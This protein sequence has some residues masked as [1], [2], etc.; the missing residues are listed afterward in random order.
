MER[1]SRK[2]IKRLREEGFEEVSTR[3]SHHKFRKGQTVLIVPHP[4]KDLPI[5]TAREIARQAGWIK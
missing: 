5:G 1:D 3:G 2:I 4:K